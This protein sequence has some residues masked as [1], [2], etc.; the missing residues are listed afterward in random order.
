MTSTHSFESVLDAA[1]LGSDWAW[2][3]LYGEI[4]APVMG[5]FRCRGVA[6]PEEA[7]GDVFLELARGVAEFDGG[8]ATFQTFVFSIAH[9]RLLTE[10]HYPKRRARSVLADQVLDRL[11]SDVEGMG[12][13][14]ATEV[15]E[16]VRRTFEML[17]IEQRDVLAMRVAGLSIEQVSEV[18]NRSGKTV[19]ELQRQ[20][21][22]RVG[23]RTWPDLIDRDLD[24][25]IDG[26]PSPTEDLAPLSSFISAL[27][28]LAAVSPSPGFVE[29]HVG[30]AVSMV[31]TSHQTVAVRA[32]RRG[33]TV[34][35]GLR[36]RVAAGATSLMMIVGL[37]GVAWASD[38]ASPGDWNYAIDRA[39]ESIGIGAG[40]AEERLLELAV[41]GQDGTPTGTVQAG[42]GGEGGTIPSQRPLASPEASGL[43]RAAITVADITAGSGRANEVRAGVSILLDYLM[44]P[45]TVDAPTV[46]DLVKQFK[47]ANANSIGHGPEDNPGQQRRPETGKPAETGKPNP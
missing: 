31:S 24:R 39:L 19:R 46:A 8:R 12:A 33:G 38:S 9:R 42:A 22:A 32:P 10:K 47:Q 18:L 3:A 11:H 2:A 37:T 44:N 45:D 26:S 6:D 36:R 14:A 7:T 43:E 4:A 35:A 25:L 23:G 29:R 40:G 21:I 34:V 1:K 13:V 20:G 15:P 41:S 16:E 30:N 5:F 17:T 27:K 28:G